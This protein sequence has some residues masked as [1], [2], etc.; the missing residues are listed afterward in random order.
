MSEVEVKPLD[1]EDKNNKKLDKN[2]D[3]NNNKEP[4][5]SKK[6]HFK[7]PS[8]IVIILSIVLIITFLTWV[9]QGQSVDTLD[10]IVTV[11]P[12]GLLAIGNQIVAG[13]ADA[14]G[15]IFYL[16]ILGWFLDVMIKSRSLESGI[17]S[18]LKA[19]KGK[20]IILVPLLFIFFAL[21]GTTYGMQEETLAF[22]I[23]IIPFFLIAGFDTM[24]G[25]LI[26][27]LGTTSGIAASIINPFS[28]GVAYDSIPIASVGDGIFFRTVI[29]ILFTIIGISFV[30][31]YAWRVKQDKNNSLTKNHYKED[32]EWAEKT[33]ETEGNSEFTK[34]QKWG[35]IVFG[36]AFLIMFLGLIPWQTFFND[37]ELLWDPTNTPPWISW[38]I[39]F[40][41][42]IGW[43]DFG[44]LIILFTI[45]T[46]TLGF[47]FK[48]KPKDLID[49]FWTGSK[50]MLS[51]AILIGIARAIPQI[52]SVSFLDVYLS[53]NIANAL[54]D[55]TG[56]AWTYSMFFVYLGLGALIPSSS[57]LASATFDLF[58]ATSANIFTDPE[59]LKGIMVSTVIVYSIAIGIINMIIPTQAVVM[60]SAER[61]RVEYT[62]MAKPVG[63][64]MGILIITTLAI[65]I[66]A[67]MMLY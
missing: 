50:D 16:F 10:G 8:S 44:E 25:L 30:T 59:Q 5:K 3:L 54:S 56:L 17:N 46:I 39:G 6:K 58:Y 15:I 64:Y 23:I 53:Q 21:G 55:V 47:I 52:L 14:S 24:T 20:E 60:A 63:V 41:N 26:I 22:Y 13:F 36:I 43:W 31:F 34:R 4:E 57:G 40:M 61:A 37:G 33:F 11:Q 42:P 28:V 45:A 2:N 66:P 12:V 67:T 9:L 38:L 18:L 65:I 7:M 29:F 1:V 19:L 62:T 48:M 35:L 27:L 32:Y 51:V 49:S